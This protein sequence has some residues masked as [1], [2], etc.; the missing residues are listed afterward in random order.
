M[1]TVTGDLIKLAQAGKFDV[2]AHGCNCMCAMGAGI[3]VPIRNAW[4]EAYAAD[5]QTEKGDRNKLGTCT[6][7]VVQQGELTVV[8]AYAQFDYRGKGVKVDYDAVASCMAWIK[9]NHS[10]KSI[11]LPMIGA[12][13]AGGDWAKIEAIIAREL[14]GEDVTIV[15]FG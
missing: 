11:G 14:D 13:L 15:E 12:G 6:Q 2:I 5:C 7:A 10:G 3:A 9:A 8:N 4:P 1:K